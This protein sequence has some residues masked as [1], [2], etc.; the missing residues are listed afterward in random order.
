MS[1]KTVSSLLDVNKEILP[2]PSFVALLATLPLGWALGWFT[3]RIG[4]VVIIVAGCRVVA[5]NI[6]FRKHCWWRL[7]FVGCFVINLNIF[8]AYKYHSIIIVCILNRWLTSSY[9]KSGN[10]LNPI[11]A[12]VACTPSV[13]W[14]RPQAV[15][16]KA[17]SW[18]SFQA[19]LVAIG[20]WVAG[21]HYIAS[22]SRRFLYDARLR[23]HSYVVPWNMK[24][25]RYWA[26][27]GRNFDGNAWSC[28]SFSWVRKVSILDDT[29]LWY[30]CMHF[31]RIGIPIQH[32]MHVLCSLSN[33]YLGVTHHN[34]CVTGVPCIWV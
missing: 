7:G 9:R 15:L 30:S 12:E 25:F 28:S 6:A 22:E 5:G 20:K 26:S 18:V 3:F 32:Q 17:R 29:I 27:M 14:E 33:G 23:I 34:A 4:W 11:A 13:L 24:I 2:W 19:F 8:S 21:N 31:E 10:D 16:F 1:W